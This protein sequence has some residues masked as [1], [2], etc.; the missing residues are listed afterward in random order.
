[1]HESGCDT[2]CKWR[3]QWGSCEQICPIDAIKY[4]PILKNWLFIAYGPLRKINVCRFFRTFLQAF[5]EVVVP[6]GGVGGQRVK[7]RT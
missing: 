6:F 1:M 3:G 4:V 5:T 7:E 2:H